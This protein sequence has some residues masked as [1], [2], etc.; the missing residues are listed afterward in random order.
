MRLHKHV[1]L[2]MRGYIAFDATGKQLVC[3]GLSGVGTAS[4]GLIRLIP[5]HGI[6]CL[7]G[8]ASPVRKVWFSRNNELIAGLTDN[9]HVGIWRIAT[10]TLLNV[11]EVPIGDTADCAGGCFD[12]TSTRFV[13]SAGNEAISYDVVTGDTLQRWKLQF[14]LFDQLQWDGQGRLLLLRREDLEQPKRRIW[15]LYAL[16]SAPTPKL[17]LQQPVP[18]WILRDLALPF[19][20]KYILAWSRSPNPEIHVYDTASGRD[21]WHETTEQIGDMRVYLDPIGET[22]GY[23]YSPLDGRLRIRRFTDFKEVKTIGSAC[24]AIAPSGRE[25]STLSFNHASCLQ[26]VYS[27]NGKL[28]AGGSENGTV[29]FVDTEQLRNSLSPFMPQ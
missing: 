28:L 19:G 22:F 3:G 5:D 11:I 1:E 8:L 14:G 13:F 15:R 29:Y 24:S 17:L 18:N 10:R 25:F 12:P 6:H 21:L 2:F 27:P 20:A 9:A 26:S 4:V 7:A 16:E 23:S